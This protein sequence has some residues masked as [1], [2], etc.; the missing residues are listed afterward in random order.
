MAR[1]LVS[2]KSATHFTAYMPNDWPHPDI[3]RLAMARRLV[4][5]PIIGT[6]P[7]NPSRDC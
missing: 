4:E 3:C 2:D 6:F 7:A 5:R 1:A